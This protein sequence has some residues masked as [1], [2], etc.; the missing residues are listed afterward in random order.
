MSVGE[1]EILLNGKT[2]T[3]RSS[4]D[5]GKRVNALG[6]GGYV[7]VNN[8][9]QAFDHDYF[10]MVVAAGLGKKPSDVESDVF[11]NGLPP[12]QLDLIKF[13]NYLAN[14]GKPFTQSRETEPGE[15]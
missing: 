11:W 2:E 13:V 1:V 7:H 3:L 12:L 14:G 6:A 9:L 10:V 5:A 4:L 8:R 15:E